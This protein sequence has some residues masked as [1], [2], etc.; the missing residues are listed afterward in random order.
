MLWRSLKA[1]QALLPCSRGALPSFPQQGAGRQFS[2]DVGSQRYESQMGGRDTFTPSSPEQSRRRKR[3]NPS[4]WLLARPLQQ[5]QPSPHFRGTPLPDPRKA[6]GCVRAKGLTAP[7]TVAAAAPLGAGLARH[8]VARRPRGSCSAD[9][10]RRAGSMARVGADPP[11]NGRV[12][13]AG[14]G[15]AAA[16]AAGGR[17]A[18]PG[19]CRC[20]GGGA[21]LR[22]P[23]GAAAAWGPLLACACRSERS[24]RPLPMGPGACGCSERSARPRAERGWS[25]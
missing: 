21:E 9:G 4:A 7:L 18:G 2:S 8:G 3:A 22:P 10:L 14:R 16:G 13:C 20:C 23:G 11:G 5:Q 6:R 15:A 17:G 19:T 25:W 12:R 24:G 1:I